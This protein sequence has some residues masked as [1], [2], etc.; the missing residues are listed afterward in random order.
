[1]NTE[2]S[3]II[4]HDDAEVLHV[5]V[6]DAPKK[7]KRGRKPLGDD[8]RRVLRI[9]TWLTKEEAATLDAARGK[10]ARGE[11]VRE[12]ALGTPIAMPPKIN[13]EAWASLGH[14]LSNLN[15][16]AKKLNSGRSVDHASLE[17]E[18]VAVRNRLLG[19]LQ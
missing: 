9:A 15:Q 19:L 7:K 5:H 2:T 10:K 18:I 16:I 8:E 1:M 14:G 4:S 12:A 11:W 6:I 3:I 13:M 17:A